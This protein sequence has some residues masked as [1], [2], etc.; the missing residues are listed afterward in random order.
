MHF[1]WLELTYSHTLTLMQ[2]HAWTHFGVATAA[3]KP[4]AVLLSGLQ[5][6][7]CQI[8]IVCERER[9]SSNKTRLRC[10]CA[11]WHRLCSASGLIWQHC[12]RVCVCECLCVP[13]LLS[14]FQCTTWGRQTLSVCC[15]S[16]A[17]HGLAANQQSCGSR[18][19]CTCL[20]CLC[21][22]LY[23]KNKVPKTQSAVAAD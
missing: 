12:R 5:V 9:E 11:M 23:S 14:K 8:L 2:G 1:V 15:A 6:K 10:V 4:L 22:V 20:R 19:N 18:I 21:S 7:C 16:L 13:K 17:C 3:G